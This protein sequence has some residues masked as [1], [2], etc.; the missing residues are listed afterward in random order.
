MTVKLGSK[1]R[2]KSCKYVLN[3]NKLKEHKRKL[4]FGYFSATTDWKHSRF[5]AF[6]TF[7][8]ILTDFR[9]AKPG[10]FQLRYFKKISDSTFY[11]PGMLLKIRISTENVLFICSQ[12]FQ[13]VLTAV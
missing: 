6:A 8:S 9:Q 12:A 10:R 5:H 11:T 3:S 13:V 4:V 1:I 2:S 7:Y